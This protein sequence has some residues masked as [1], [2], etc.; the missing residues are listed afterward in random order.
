M[1]IEET[2]ESV[3]IPDTQTRELNQKLVEEAAEF[4]TR[5]VLERGA[6]FNDG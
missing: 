5:Q 6:T 2:I 4:V 3:S 1:V